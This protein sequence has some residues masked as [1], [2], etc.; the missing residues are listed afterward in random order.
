MANKSTTRRGFLSTG[1]PSKR[2][3]KTKPGDHPDADLIRCCVAYASAIAGAAAAYK[4]D[5]TSDCDFANATDG[6]ALATA[7]KLMG[8]AANYLPTT[9]DGLRAKGEIIEL[10]M[11]T[12][13]DTASAISFMRSVADDIARFHKAAMA[14]A[15]VRPG[16]AAQS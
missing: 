2:T 12:E 7:R 5:P 14:T 6:R 11:E 9:L 10:I 1:V 3:T 4:A 16:I 13:V 15:D 8:H